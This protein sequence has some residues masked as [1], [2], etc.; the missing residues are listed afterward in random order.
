[1]KNILAT[2]SLAV[3]ALFT[4][5]TP[6]EFNDYELGALYSIG[7]DKITF[8][9]TPGANQWTYNYTATVDVDP[10]KYPFV[11]EIRY[12]D[13]N[14]GKTLSGTYEYIVPAGTYTAELVVYT[15]DG[16]VTKK[17]KDIVVTVDNPKIFQDDP[18]SL[19]FALTGGKD[20]TGG[21][22]WTLGPKTY[23]C[24]P[25]NRGEVWW[26]YNGPEPA[27]MNDV[28]T[29]K[30]NVIQ[31]NGAYSYETNGDCFINE[32][33]G[34]LFA[35]GSTAGSFVTTLYNPPGDA[36]WSFSTQDG[37]TILTIN[38]GF[39]G[40]AIAPSDLQKTEYIVLSYSPTSIVLAYAASPMWQF[41]LIAGES[42]EVIDLTGGTSEING[43]SWKLRPNSG[44]I[45][46][47]TI[48]GE[49]WWTIDATAAGSEAAY[50]DILTFYANG[51]AKID[52][53]GN[54]FMN[55]STATLFTD[56]QTDGS[57]VTV[58]YVPSNDAAW[59]FTK[60]AGT[61]YL[62][63]SKVFPMYGL[64]PEVI[65]HGLYEIIEI[66]ET[67]V[68]I[69]YIVGTGEWDVTWNFYLVPA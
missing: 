69:K 5:C 10:V 11:C 26:N 57:F 1:M 50:D 30:P 59:R 41:E 65:E 18:A 4:A 3:L 22:A 31:P 13:G 63:L 68:H 46:T 27:M 14:A 45:M 28:I 44:I 9:F 58:E 15:P 47:R 20:N 55:E 35:D 23:M 8:N 53:H 7:E 52:N 62:E 24:N 42:Q 17:S 67:L 43:K 32:T 2:V 54:S 19:Q 37:K 49:V 56:G 33:L 36:S 39:V 16:T 51:K 38:K 21:K 29:F 61:D 64:T 40:Y 25:D 48:T 66:S 6:Q 34:D 12:G 60:V